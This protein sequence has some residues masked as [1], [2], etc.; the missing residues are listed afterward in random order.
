MTD[1][2]E[3]LGPLLEQNFFVIGLACIGIFTIVAVLADIQRT[4]RQRS[5]A[6]SAEVDKYDTEN[7]LGI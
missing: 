1:L 4:E 7:D 5:E 6:Q 2:I 3:K